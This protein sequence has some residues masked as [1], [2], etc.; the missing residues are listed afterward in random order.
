MPSAV[1]YQ[2]VDRRNVCAIIV[3]YFPDQSFGAYLA[4]IAAQYPRVLI[5]DNG[6]HPGEL[7]RLCGQAPERIE[8]CSMDGNAGLGA[9]LNHGIQQAIAMGYCWATL[10]DQDSEPLT[11]LPE[12]FAAL[13][14]THPDPARV[15]I[16][17]ARFQD[18]NKPRAEQ[19][20][21]PMRSGPLWSAKRRVIT[22]GSLLSLAAYEE[23]GM[24]REDYFIDS[25]DHEYCYRA[26]QHGWQVLESTTTLL[27][28]SVGAKRP[29]S[30]LGKQIWRSHHSAIRCYFM[31]RNR[32]LL[33]WEYRQYGKL[34][35]ES[36][37]CLRELFWILLYER[38]KLAK[39]RATLVGCLHGLCNCPTMPAWI[40]RVA[41]A[42]IRA[43]E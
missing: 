10:F 27:M 39:V 1:P 25:I 42:R 16:V 30:F 41:G 19:P 31:A 3:T 36:L 29:H 28:H 37:R 40:A 17:G 43:A 13:L 8:L 14:A 21:A 20:A 11:D 24:F 6:S 22:S 4:T 38:D 7:E 12:H 33:A 15:A 2:A 35:R 34:V 18:R 26:A 9:A 32:M 23:L 5:I